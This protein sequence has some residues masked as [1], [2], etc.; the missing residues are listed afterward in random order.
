MI[1]NSGRYV[2][3]YNG[4]IYN[5]LQIRRELEGINSKIIWK[6]YS[7]T[8]TLIEAIDFWGIETSLKKD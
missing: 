2:L 5:H 4:E 1:S 7:D 3:T 6:G 8:E